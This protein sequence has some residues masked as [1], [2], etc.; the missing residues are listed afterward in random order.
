MLH[1][2][3]GCQPRLEGRKRLCLGRRAVSVGVGGPDGVA[4]PNLLPSFRLET[5]A[6]IIT[7]LE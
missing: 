2:T 7:C 6:D 5:G 4:I 3:E 1:L